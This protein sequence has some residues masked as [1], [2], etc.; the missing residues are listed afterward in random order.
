MLIYNAARTIG[1]LLLLAGSLSLASH[2][3]GQFRIGS[4]PSETLIGGAA[5]LMFGVLVCLLGG[6]GRRVVRLEEQLAAD[7]QVDPDIQNENDILS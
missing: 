2:L 7:R 1:G 3:A 6:I 5:A 4:A